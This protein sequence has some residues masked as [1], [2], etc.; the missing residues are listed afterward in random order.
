[1]ANLTVIS[2]TAVPDHVRGALSRWMVEPTPGLYVGTLSAKV[3]EELWAVVAAS[4]ADGA[5]VLVHPTDNE[6]HFALRTAGERRRT[7]LDFDGLTLIA[8]NPAEP[9]NET[10]KTV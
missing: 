7:T 3:R 5:A 10:A 2:T 6:Q 1:M 9:D 8:L 4:I